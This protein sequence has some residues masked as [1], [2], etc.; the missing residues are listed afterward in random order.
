M[1]N[2]IFVRIIKLTFGTTDLVIESIIVY[3]KYLHFTLLTTL[4]RLLRL[5]QRAWNVAQ[6]WKFRSGPY[7]SCK[8]LR[9]GPLKRAQL[10]KQTG[11]RIWTAEKL[12][13]KFHISFINVSWQE[14]MS[15]WR[16]ILC[17]LPN[18]THTELIWV[19]ETKVCSALFINTGVFLFFSLRKQKQRSWRL[20]FARRLVCHGLE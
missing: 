19:D 2:K 10:A 8:W 17:E 5:L 14:W 6:G 12:E 3:L 9:S 15:E 11:F 13:K 16:T 18:I 1:S 20:V 4:L 7:W